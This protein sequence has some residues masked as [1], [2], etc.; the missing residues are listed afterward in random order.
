MNRLAIGV[1]A[2]AMT[3]LISTRLEHFRR[4]NNFWTQRD[5]WPVDTRGYIFL[6]GAFETVGRARFG[7]SWFGDDD[8]PPLPPQPD[9]NASDEIWDRYE[10]E[11]DLILDTVRRNSLSVA[12]EIVEACRTGTLDS[13]I[14]EK[15]GG[16]I[17]AIEPGLWNFENWHRRFWCCQMS[18]LDPF[19]NA[20]ST[21]FIFIGRIRLNSFV[22]MPKRVEIP[23]VGRSKDWKIQAAIEAI[24]EIPGLD[25]LKERARIEAVENHLKK[26]G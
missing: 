20:S 24:Y 9:S 17:A 4:D 22:E 23:F 8:D 14:R 18:K 11:S 25:E 1:A 2:T 12:E 19:S 5:K 10:S 26:S 15:A 7:K 21:H 16:Q 13:G 6:A 3:R